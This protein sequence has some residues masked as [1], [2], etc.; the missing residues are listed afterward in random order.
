MIFVAEDFL[1]FF[2]VADDFFADDFSADDFVCGCFVF[3]CGLFCL[4]MIYA[5]DG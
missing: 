5:A 1:C 4:R 3:F 2:V